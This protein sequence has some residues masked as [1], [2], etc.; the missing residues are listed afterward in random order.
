M[1]LLLGKFV[2]SVPGVGVAVLDEVPDRC[3]KKRWKRGPKNRSR[4]CQKKHSK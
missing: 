2:D 3:L 1:Y 4:R